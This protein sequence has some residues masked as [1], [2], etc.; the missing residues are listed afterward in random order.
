LVLKQYD[1]NPDGIK[2]RVNWEHMLISY[3]VFILCINTRAAV[4]QVKAIAKLKGWEL[5]TRVVIEEGKL[6]VRAWRTN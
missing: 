4:R 2:I 1:L 3:S 5:E 6:G